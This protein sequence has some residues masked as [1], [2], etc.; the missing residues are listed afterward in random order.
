MTYKNSVVYRWAKDTP[1]S[2][3]GFGTVVKRLRQRVDMPH[4]LPNKRYLYEYLINRLKLD[5]QLVESAIDDLWSSY[6]A[7]NLRASTSQQETA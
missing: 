2:S 3:N 4:R 6:Y 7:F 1:A 5:P